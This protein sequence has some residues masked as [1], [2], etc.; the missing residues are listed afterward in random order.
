MKPKCALVRLIVL[1]CVPT[2][3]GGR[4]KEPSILHSAGARSQITRYR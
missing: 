3:E 1:K 4:Q 2:K